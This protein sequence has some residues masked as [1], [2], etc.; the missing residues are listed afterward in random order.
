MVNHGYKGIFIDD[1]NMEFRVSDGNGNFV[2]PID[3]NTGTGMTLDNWR[4]HM[5]GFMEQVRSAFPN[6]E[7]VHNSIWYAGAGNDK[8]RQ[9]AAANYQYI[10]FGVNDGGLTGGTGQW[11]LNNMLG[12]I[13]GLHAANRSVIISGVPLDTAAREYATAN[14]FLISGG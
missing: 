13:E 1:V 6:N 11:S 5:A 4:S 8:N 9:I 14:Y 3:P 7:I 10:E 2:D 12:Y